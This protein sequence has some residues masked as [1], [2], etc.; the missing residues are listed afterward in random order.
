MEKVVYAGIIIGAILF[1]FAGLIM[2]KTR[3]Y[4]YKGQVVTRD[5]KSKRGNIGFYMG[6]TGL[7]LLV[8]F[9]IIGHG[10]LSLW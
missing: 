8:V 2:P 3:R 9:G 6:L 7:I 4:L 10:I 5:D 1:I